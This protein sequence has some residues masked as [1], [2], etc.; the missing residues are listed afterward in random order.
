MKLA[1]K[2]VRLGVEMAEA[3]GY[4]ARFCKMA[5]KYYEDAIEQGYGDEDCNAVYKV[6]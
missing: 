1:H 3:F 6:I 2:D 4:D 5:K